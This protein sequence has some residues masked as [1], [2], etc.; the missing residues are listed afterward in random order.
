MENHDI[1]LVWWISISLCLATIATI[2]ITG[3]K[4]RRHPN[5]IPKKTLF[6]AIGLLP[7]SVLYFSDIT[8]LQSMKD[9]EFCSSCH[10]MQPFV[11]GLYDEESEGLA[12][13]H[14]QHIRI[15]ENP[16]YTC[17]SDYQ[18]LGGV[19]DKIRGLRH[20]LA[21]Y[22]KDENERP[23]LY[24]PYPNE[25]CFSCHMESSTFMDIEDHADNIEELMTD[26]VSCLECHGPSH[27]EK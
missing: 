16:C 11:D 26:D 12:A 6:F 17:H 20:M 9:E 18:I 19:R 10:I 3:I 2:I 5:Q 7:L 25:N 14:V 21:F 13:Q 23:K 22:I 15:R 4:G 1:D 27:P 24:D 8:I